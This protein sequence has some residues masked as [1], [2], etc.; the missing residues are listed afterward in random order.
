[1]GHCRSCDK[2]RAT[3]TSIA[4][5]VLAEADEY[6]T[7]VPKTKHLAPITR[8]LDNAIHWIKL[9]TVDTL[10][11]RRA[12]IPWVRKIDWV[13]AFDLAMCVKAKQIQW[14]L[15]NKFSDVVIRMG[16]FHIALNF[17]VIIGKKYL[18]SGLEDLLIENRTHSP[19]PACINLE[20]RHPSTHQVTGV[21]C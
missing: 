11:H 6:G 16:T 8:K 3:D 7:V 14:R 18:N 10:I 12:I 21:V 20:W 19:L 15:A 5:K 4:A 1:M 13:I 17:L 9:Y 2:L